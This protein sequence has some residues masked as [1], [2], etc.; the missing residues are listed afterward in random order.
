ADIIAGKIAESQIPPDVIEAFHAQ[1]PQ[2]GSSFVDA[3]NHLSA[4][5]DQLAGLISGVK[6]KLFEIDYIEW[7]NNGHLPTGW[8]AELAGH[9]NN[10]AW[11]VAILDAHGRLDEVLQLK[12]TES[13]A[14]V[15]EAIAAHPD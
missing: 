4:H 13:L 5:P 2:Y 14:Y 10:P 15:K 8:T 11:D 1:Y 7:L 12:A 9:A 6:G 3:V